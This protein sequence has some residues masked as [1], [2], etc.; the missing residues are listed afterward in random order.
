MNRSESYNKSWPRRCALPGCGEPLTVDALNGST[1]LYY[2]TEHRVAARRHRA[3]ERAP[4]M[5]GGTDPRAASPVSEGHQW[6]ILIPDPDY[7]RQ[8]SARACGGRKVVITLVLL[9]V[10][11][12]VIGY[13]MHGAADLHVGASVGI[14]SPDPPPPPRTHEIGPVARPP[15]TSRPIQPDGSG[16]P[17]HKEQ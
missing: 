7:E 17:T 13:E 6:G 12:A 11:G 10:G 2:C 16:A 15:I 8:R 14:A 9:A 1:P 3:R 4:S 5:G